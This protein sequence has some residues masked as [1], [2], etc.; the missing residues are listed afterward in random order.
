MSIQT[1][2]D[3]ERYRR[4]NGTH[5][6]MPETEAKGDY[7]LTKCGQRVMDCWILSEAAAEFVTCPNCK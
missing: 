4:E 5:R 6:R 1:E 3:L 2:F 7:G